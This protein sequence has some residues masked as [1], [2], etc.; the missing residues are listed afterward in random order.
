MRGLVV[1]RGNKKL[2]HCPHN[3]TTARMFKRVW[4]CMFM[5]MHVLFKMNYVTAVV[6][7]VNQSTQQQH[8]RCCGAASWTRGILWCSL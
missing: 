6:A 1:G 7:T 4:V 5:C 8:N 2:C 3:E